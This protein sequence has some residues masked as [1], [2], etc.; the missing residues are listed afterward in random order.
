MTP[1]GA[2]S[3]S[4][5]LSCLWPAGGLRLAQYLQAKPCGR[6]PSELSKGDSQTL[7]LGYMRRSLSSHPGCEPWPLRASGSVLRKCQ[8]P[9]ALGTPVGSRERLG[10]HRLC[11]PWHCRPLVRVSMVG[12]LVSS[13]FSPPHGLTNLESCRP[14]LGTQ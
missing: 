6:H 7:L 2:L 9:L 12:I 3:V 4:K 13:F 1:A 5:P 8:M 14:I 10:I 11:M